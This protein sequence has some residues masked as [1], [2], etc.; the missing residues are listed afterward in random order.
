MGVTGTV[1]EKVTRFD[2]K[3]V[4]DALRA[5]K[6]GKNKLS[7]LVLGRDA[8]Y[9]S[10][11]ITSGKCNKDDLKKVCEFLS[12]D[13]DSI[14]ITDN[15]IPKTEN[16]KTPKEVVNFDALIIGVNQ[17]YQIEKQN[18]EIMQNILQELKVSNTKT[19]RL[20]NLIGQIHTNTISIKDNTKEI[21]NVS[22][23]TKS[24]VMTIAGRVR[25]MLAKFKG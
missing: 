15:E 14:I 11:A 6:L 5:M 1:T 25:D 13:Y 12:L 4:D 18:G 16:P 10:G 7:T 24:G 2:A 9:M 23:E 3:K 22:R 20:E 19:N 8:S 21:E 17:L